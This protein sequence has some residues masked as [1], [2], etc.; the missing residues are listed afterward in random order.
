[1]LLLIYIR[2]SLTTACLV[3]FEVTIVQPMGTVTAFHSYVII[4]SVL[5]NQ[6]LKSSVNGKINGEQVYKPTE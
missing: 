1:M 5:H 6:L 2:A 3:T 4:M